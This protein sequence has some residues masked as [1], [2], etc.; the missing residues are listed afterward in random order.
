MGGSLLRA[1]ATVKAWSGEPLAPGMTSAAAAVTGG[2]PPSSS[3][4][5]GTLNSVARRRGSC[6]NGV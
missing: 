4:A 3:S 1:P 2:P 5:W 6:G